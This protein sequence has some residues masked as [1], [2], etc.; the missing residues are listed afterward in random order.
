MPRRFPRH[1]AVLLAFGL[2][3]LALAA[4]AGASP[5]RYPKVA[6]MIREAGG[7]SPAQFDTLSW[8]DMV[9]MWE[10]P[11][12]VEQ[13]RARNPDIRLLFNCMPQNFVAWGESDST[14]Y[15]DTTWSITRLAQFYGQKNDW[16][17]YNIYGE[18]IP[19]WD[20]YEANWTRYCPVGTH[21][22]SQ[23]LRYVDWLIQVAIPQ[24]VEG[25]SLWGPWGSESSAYNGFMFEVLADCLGS[26]GWQTYQYADPDRDGEAEGVYTDCVLGGDQDSLSI[27]YREMNEVFYEGIRPLMDQGLTL[28][29][30]GS[31]KQINPWWQTRLSGIKLEGWKSLNQNHAH[32]TWRSWFYGL[33]NWDRTD[34][35]GPGYKWAEDLSDPAAVDSL[36]GWDQSFLQ[37]FPRWTTPDSTR[38]RLRRWGLA[39]TLLGDGYY[40]FTMNQRDLWWEPEYDW[41]FGEPL[42]DFFREPYPS[43]TGIDTV[44]V[45][46]FGKGFVEVNP[47]AFPLHGIPSEDAR[48]GFWQTVEELQADSLGGDRASVRF[49]FPDSEVSAVESVE[50]RYAPFPLSVATWS[51]A[52]PYAGNPITRPL[53]GGPVEV[54]LTGLNPGT[55]YQVAARNRVFGRQEPGISAVASFTTAPLPPDHDPPRTIGDVTP[56]R[57][58]SLQV[59]LEWTAPGDDGGEG[60]AD[61]YEIRFLLG[62]AITT[63]QDWEEATPA[64]PPLPAPQPAG[65]WEHYSVMSLSPETSYGFAVRAFDEAGNR[66]GLSNPLLVTTAS[67][68][69]SPEQPS[70]PPT[71]LL[72][73]D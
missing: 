44:Y 51:Q 38:V 8:Y 22:T 18:R 45:R 72:P 54:E 34:V 35:W 64:P 71:P 53:G 32:W 40:S 69:I 25:D 7:Y 63:E 39:T 52:T 50:L 47:N 5:G 61:H 21:G 59:R 1:H 55:H 48:I 11:Y 37:V 49:D 3:F 46:V 20:G 68:P 9:V 65:S 56:A 14:W 70:F 27:L 73:P 24:I 67:P 41:D 36:H 58:D 12:F 10:A 66:G 23:G 4:R 62:Q 19:A 60:T 16:Y 33:D 26:V 6:Q 30:N 17:L 2:L 29:I 13:L 43:A 42:G 28:I 57:V 31:L 15:P